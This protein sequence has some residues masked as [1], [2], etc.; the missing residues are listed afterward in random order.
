MAVLLTGLSNSYLLYGDV[1]S[2][3]GHFR[4]SIPII[5]K[6]VPF[7]AKIDFVIGEAPFV[8]YRFVGEPGQRY[9][10]QFIYQKTGLLLA[11]EARMENVSVLSNSFSGYSISFGNN[12]AVTEIRHGTQ[13]L[14]RASGSTS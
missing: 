10:D 13:V 4:Q 2:W 6:D 8:T 5:A 9:V 12:L 11:V 7:G 1:L 14:Y 3:S